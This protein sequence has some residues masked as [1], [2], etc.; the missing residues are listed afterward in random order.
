MNHRARVFNTAIVLGFTC[1]SFTARA[2]ESVVDGGSVEII[3]KRPVQDPGQIVSTN[4]DW[5]QPGL[6]SSPTKRY[7][8]GDSPAWIQ[9][10]N[11]S[12]LPKLTCGG[13]VPDTNP[14]APHPVVIATGEKF[15]LERDFVATSTTG[16]SIERTYRSKPR[17]GRLFGPNWVAGFEHANLQFGDRI[18]NELMW[19]KLV[20]P[21]GAEHILNK[22]N[23]PPGGFPPGIAVYYGSFGTLTF[24]GDKN[25]YI[26]NKDGVRYTY[27]AD[28]RF[29]SLATNNGSL[30]F[31]YVWK[32]DS[33]NTLFA[34][35]NGAGQ[36]MLF[37]WSNDRVTEVSDPNGQIWK[38]SYNANNMLTKVT[39]PVDAAS[40]AP[41]NYRE[42]LYEN[43]GDATL[44]T[45]IKVNGVRYST[46]QYDASKR[47]IDSALA[48]REE[49]ETFVY[50]TNYT[51]VTDARGQT[52][53]YTYFDYYGNK[54][55]VSQSRSST[56]SCAAAA[57]ST[58]YDSYGNIDYTLDW[59]GNK[60]QYV[61]NSDKAL[62]SVTTAAGT[63]NAQTKFN[64]W[65]GTILTS[66]EYRD[67]NGSAFR[68]ISYT[69]K[70]NSAGLA[71]GLLD[72]VTDT[73][74]NSA[75]QRKTGYAYTHY[76]DGMLATLT[77]TYFLASGNETEVVSYDAFGNLSS[78]TNRLGQVE[79]F[80][81]H[82]KLGN[83]ATAVD[84]NGISHTFAYNLNTTLKSATDK[85]PTGDRA[86]TFTYNGDNKL[87]DIV[88]PDGT[89][90]R[91]RY[92]A[93]GRLE[94]IGDAQ[95][96]FTT[97]AYTPATATTVTT[98]GRF[99]PGLSGST[100]TAVAATDFSASSTADTLG[101]TYTTTGNNGQSTSLRYDR[102]GNL[103]SVTDANGNSTTFDY[104]YQ[105]RRTKVKAL[106]EGSVTER[107]YNAAGDLDWVRDAR[108]LQTNYT[109]NGYGELTSTDSPDTGLTTYS[110][111]GNGRLGRE[112]RENGVVID[113]TWDALGRIKTRVSGAL[114]ETFTYDAGSYGKGHLSSI[115]D[116]SGQ[117]SYS[118]TAAGELSNK[119]SVI[120]GQTFSTGWTY[121]AAGRLQT[122]SYPSGLTLTY[123]YDG[124]GRL[125][126]VSSSLAGTWATL[127]DS[128]LYQPVQG[129]PYAWRFANNRARLLT[130]DRDGRLA[131]ID[132]TTAV[133]QMDIGYDAGNRLTAR[134]DNVDT[135]KS[136]SYGYDGTSRLTSAARPAGGE[137]FA[138][139][140]VGNRTAHNSGAGNFTLT[141][142][143]Q[144]NRLSTWSTAA[145][146]QYRNFSYDLVGNLLS[147]S[148]KSGGVV[149]AYDYGHD[150]FNRLLSVKINGGAVGTYAYNAQNLRVQ[151]VSAAGTTRYVYGPSGELLAEAGPVATDY[152]WFD[153]QLF[154]I[155]RAG[156][157]YASHNDQV[158]RPE[159]L[160]NSAGTP[161]WRADNK[162]FDRTVTLNTVPLNLGLPGQ[163]YDSETGLW[164][165]WHRYYDAS[166]GRYI[167][168]DPI[169]LAG[170][171]NTYAYVSGN[172]LSL[173]DPMGLSQQDVDE[174][175]CFARANNADLKI[176]DPE[177]APIPQTRAEKQNGMEQAGHVDRYPWSGVVINSNRYGGKLTPAQR[178]DL[179]NT[180]IH[181]S[182]HYDKQPFYARNSEAEPTREGNARAAKVAP[183]ILSGN[184]GSCGCKKK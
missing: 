48:G 130:Y 63:A 112:T 12:G 107:H 23:P 169:G 42:Y 116:A 51:D 172:P 44:L 21:T 27:W 133:Q 100:P 164:Y 143:S 78:S 93:G 177:F 170:G 132:S 102:N 105:Q 62:V 162:A 120:T 151:K 184:I 155:V 176:P 149:S 28:G 125:N 7:G 141:L 4:V 101:R 124:Y 153:G 85:L 160:T 137:T 97:I 71:A 26:L 92:N 52:T 98:S 173:V 20:D 58:F 55:I 57:A 156:Q 6:P 37:T 84:I 86:T 68:R 34:I 128:F 106:P 3:G 31:R 80:S 17:G 104:D 174:M 36:S 32:W 67:A 108:G 109:Y 111:D 96:S 166:L 76:S 74:L 179:Y 50:G 10:Q 16:L 60:T 168:S 39:A 139:D 148:R 175:T 9:A 126:R 138:W 35:A 154:G 113:Y 89:A 167:Q 18:N 135:S 64:N 29:D 73:D 8:P 49:F 110:Y 171:M 118:Y 79:S 87:T 72:T 94:K 5:S 181:E 81:G 91:Y 121:D 19:I 119:T 150:A 43:T 77:K 45:G 11:N 122:M 53:R 54:R 178:L 22:V 161:V 182:W 103:K 30:L 82:D 2:Q 114:S 158:G 56:A 90:L 115:V 165:N 117:T 129:M 65:V 47:V 15:K 59:E 123:W 14:A 145:N 61:F 140:L 99:T 142:D 25:Q 69:Y 183:Q 163:Q 40:G 131:R 134:S 33:P 88:R 157:F 46:Y 144:S 41:A 159:V 24:Y 1:A 147:E 75:T 180:I 127:A 146:D 136:A 70:D 66:T 13:E 152:V 83:P 38:Y 95:N